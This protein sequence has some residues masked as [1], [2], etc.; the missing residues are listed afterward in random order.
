[1]KCTFNMPT[2]LLKT[3]RQLGKKS[4]I[5]RHGRINSHYDNAR[6]WRSH[7]FDG[8]EFLQASYARQS[9]PMHMH[10]T[11]V[12]GVILRGAEQFLYRG[13]TYIAPEG[14]II[15]IPPYEVHTGNPAPGTVWQYKSIYPS[16]RL[17]QSIIKQIDTR[18][19]DIPNFTNPVIND[20]DLATEILALHH[21]LRYETDMNFLESEMITT[22]IKLINRHSEDPQCDAEIVCNHE[23]IVMA[24]D[25]I[26]DNI[27]ERVSLRV[28]SSVVGLSQY[29]LISGFK[30]N[31]GLPP[32]RFQLNMRIMQA[33]RMLADGK[34]IAATAYDLGFSDQSHFI[35]HFRSILGVTP[36]QYF[37]QSIN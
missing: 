2:E 13:S 30:K 19:E 14:S 11:F 35:R 18:Y 32:H 20:I 3:D 36:G 7:S 24:R 4:A 34:S 5:S 8:V 17:V 12:L 23:S 37:R 28:I 33:R 6:M 29:Q 27:A 22:L 31:F 9:F 16:I 26:M 10:E 21:A 25:Y 1:M 15:M